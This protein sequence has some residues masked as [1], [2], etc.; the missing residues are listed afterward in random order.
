MPLQVMS[1]HMPLASAAFQHHSRSMTPTFKSW[2][3]WENV[4][5][6][7][8]TRGYL[9]WQYYLNHKGQ[10]L[11]MGGK[12]GGKGREATNPTWGVACLGPCA[13]P[14]AIHRMNKPH[15]SSSKRSGKFG[16]KRK[17]MCLRR[18]IGKW[19]EVL[20]TQVKKTDMHAQ[21]PLHHLSGEFVQSCGRGFLKYF[22]KSVTFGHK[23]TQRNHFVIFSKAPK[24][25]L[26]HWW[27]K[28]GTQSGKEVNSYY[29]FVQIPWCKLTREHAHGSWG[30]TDSLFRSSP[31]STK[32]PEVLR[33]FY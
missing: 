33:S 3:E 13:M 15:A 17:F 28:T 19:G 1:T 7:L 31:S 2:G 12:W 6:V 18:L 23:R 21:L 22:L 26:S 32:S 4:L 11:G 25:E 14:C 8:L 20:F 9:N 29:W 5:P 24:M 10:S 30:H 16:P 27:V